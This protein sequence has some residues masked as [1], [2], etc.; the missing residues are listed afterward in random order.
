M[1]YF[2]GLISA[3]TKDEA[4][5]I[6]LKLN[7]LKLIAGGLISGGESAYWWEGEVTEKEY[8]NLSI[9]TVD[10]NRERIISTVEAV[11]SDKVPIIA[12]FEITSGN[13]S[14]LEWIKS[15]TCSG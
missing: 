5:E 15:C 3:T 2:R 10:I 9:F 14:F 4:K 6:L 12:F 11:H 7:E 8:F 1:K 13:Q